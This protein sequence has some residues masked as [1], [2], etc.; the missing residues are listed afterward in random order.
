MLKTSEISKLSAKELNE[1]VA[2]LKSD[3]FNNRFTKFT[4]GSDKPH[5]VKE[6][7]KDIARLLTFKNTK[8]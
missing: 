8:K 3:M 1:K 5:V 6:L 2:S 7:K 4:T